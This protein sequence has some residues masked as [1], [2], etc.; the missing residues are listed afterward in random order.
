MHVCQW[1][2]GVL[3]IDPRA[4]AQ[5]QHPVKHETQFCHIIFFI[6]STY[7]FLLCLGVCTMVCPFKFCIYV[8]VFDL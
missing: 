1:A 4:K 5:V 6:M 7:V 8:S 2:G 3:L